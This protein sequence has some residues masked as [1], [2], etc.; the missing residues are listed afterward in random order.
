[1]K[2]LLFA[3]LAF[4]LTYDASAKTCDCVSPIVESRIQG[5]SDTG[6]ADRYPW[7]AALAFAADAIPFCGGSLLNNRYV[8]TAARCT[9]G[10][11]STECL[12]YFNSFMLTE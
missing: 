7:N 5:G 4:A 6:G 12:R 3:V 8:L 10:K 1:M 11:V 9:V 2:F